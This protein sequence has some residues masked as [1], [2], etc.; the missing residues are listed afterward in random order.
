MS[1]C[2]EKRSA[3]ATFPSLKFKTPRRI[4]QKYADLAGIFL[5]PDNRGGW[6]HTAVY[7]TAPS[8]NTAPR[9]SASRFN[10]PSARRQRSPRNPSPRKVC[11]LGTAGTFSPNDSGR[12]AAA[13]LAGKTSWQITSAGGSQRSAARVGSYGQ[14]TLKAKM[15]APRRKTSKGDRLGGGN[16]GMGNAGKLRTKWRKEPEATSAALPPI[17]A[18]D[19][20]DGEQ[21]RRSRGLE[22][23]DATDPAR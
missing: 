19:L 21:F 9:T 11:F 1:F 10:T 16:A 13:G 22:L 18:S 20:D 23:L 8:R 17:P 7:S 15:M 14:R 12:P 5:N 2:I 4:H 3:Y 6:V